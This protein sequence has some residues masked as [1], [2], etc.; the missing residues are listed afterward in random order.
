M[1]IIASILGGLVSGLFTFLGVYLTIKYQHKK[2]KKEEQ[3]HLEHEKKLQILNRPR[4]TITDYNSEHSYN[5]DN[6]ND[7]ILLMVT[8]K[9]CISCSAFKYDPLMI[10]QKNWISIEYTLK[11]SGNTEINKIFVSTNFPQNS[12]LF[13]IKINEHSYCYENECLNNCVNLEKVL[14]PNDSM[15]LQI[16]YIKNKVIVSTAETS[17]P[18]SIWLMDC[19]Y[20]FWIQKLN[21]P[22]NEISNSKLT[23]SKE[24]TD[25]VDIRIP[26]NYFKNRKYNNIRIL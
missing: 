7:M 6:C 3:L 4:L 5:N 21:A 19:N 26:I 20:N 12:A 14:L 2:D 18:L 17:P 22:N 13:D 8:I 9:E 23:T 1:D 11:N 10:D 24:L 25:A 15:I 16:N